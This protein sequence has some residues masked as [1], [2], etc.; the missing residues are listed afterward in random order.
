V[1]EIDL[2]TID[3]MGKGEEVS[4]TTFRRDWLNR[5]YGRSAGLWTAKL[6]GDYPPLDLTEGDYVVCCDAT[7]EELHERQL[8]I[9]RAP[10]LGKLL[11]ARFTFVHRGDSV[12]AIEDGEYWVNP[13]LLPDAIVE[14]GGGDLLPVGRILGRAFAPIR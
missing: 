6:P 4:R 14:H 8:C 7:R 10:I 1:P 2:K 13:Y 3:D 11:I 9:W 5:S 12:V